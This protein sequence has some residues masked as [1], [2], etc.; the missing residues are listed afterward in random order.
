MDE[1]DIL[2]SL[3]PVFGAQKPFQI[4]WINLFHFK[5]LI[6]CVVGVYLFIY[7]YIYI[8]IVYLFIYIFFF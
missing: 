5:Q 1:N 6:N 8:F 3:V 4:C 2:F 7:F